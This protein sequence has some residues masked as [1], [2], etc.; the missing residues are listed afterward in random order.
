MTNDAPSQL[1][2]GA[3]TAEIPTARLQ[4][5]DLQKIGAWV[6]EAEL[7]RRAEPDIKARRQPGP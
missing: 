3:N 6:V 4:V 1:L 7:L 2:C 5:V